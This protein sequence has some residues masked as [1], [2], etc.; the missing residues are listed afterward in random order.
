MAGERWMDYLK[1]DS[2]ELSVVCK[3]GN[4]I[5]IRYFVLGET[6]EV[7]KDHQKPSDMLA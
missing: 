3:I 1:E 6:G 7:P 5:L 2:W 4:P